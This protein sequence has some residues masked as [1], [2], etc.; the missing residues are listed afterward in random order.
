M[1]RLSHG[2]MALGVLL[3]PFLVYWGVHSGELTLLGVVL[4]LLFIA[5]LIPSAGRLGEWLWLG[6]WMAG[7]GLLLTLLSLA[8]RASHWLLFYPVLVNVLL[9]ILFAHSLWQPQTLI[10]RFARLQDPTLPETA[11]AYTRRVT[12]IWCLFFILNGTLALGTVLIGNMAWWSLYNGLISYL[13]MAALMG[14]EWLVRR[15]VQARQA[16]RAAGE[17]AA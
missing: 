10:E 7:C 16:T 4:T 14:G 15:R 5:R 13:L 9:L 8:C 12:Q 11:I 6:R 2:L 1:G 17:S 3:Y